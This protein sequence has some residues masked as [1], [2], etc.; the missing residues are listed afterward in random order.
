MLF[1]FP[2]RY[3]FTIGHIVVF[4]LRRWASCLPPRFLVP[5]RTPDT[6]N[7]YLD[8]TYMDLTFFVPAFQPS[9][10]ISVLGI[11]Q[12]LPLHHCWLRFG[13]L[14]FRSPLLSESTLFF[15]LLPVLRCFSS[16]RSPLT[17]IYSL[18][19]N[20]LL[21]HCVPTFGYLRIIAHLQLPAA[22]RSLSRP[23]SALC[24]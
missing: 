23:S 14:R 1:T 5:Q 12:S 10:V 13:L 19:S 9:S 17:T 8:F 2:S 6:A 18:L 15:L 21:M 16:R 3:W 22:F 20:A 7:L 24:A 11:S 4:S